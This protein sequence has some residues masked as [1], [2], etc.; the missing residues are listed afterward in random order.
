MSRR[1]WC[2]FQSFFSSSCTGCAL[3]AFALSAFLW[4]NCKLH[5]AMSDSINALKAW[6][7]LSNATVLYDS[8]T[9]EFTHNGLFHAVIGKPNVALVATTTDGDLFGAFYSAALSSQDSVSFDPHLFAFSFESHGRCATPKRF[10]P[11]DVNQARVWVYSSYEMGFVMVCGTA[12]GFFLLG[13]ERSNTTCNTLSTV[14][15]DMEDT[16][17]TGTSLGDGV[18]TYRCARLIAVQLS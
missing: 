6:T 17:L 16:T 12:K 3:W 11:K 4:T 9:D 8:M 7:G 18:N 13:N 14:F 10:V 1:H 2:I 15:E 5:S